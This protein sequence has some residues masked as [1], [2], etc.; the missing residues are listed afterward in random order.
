MLKYQR[1]FCLK[2]PALLVQ[3]LLVKH[4]HDVLANLS[5][6]SWV[7]PHMLGE[8]TLNLSPVLIQLQLNYTSLFPQVHVI[9]RNIPY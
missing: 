1:V 3:C 8:Y 6:S 5:I 7:N 4:A 9:Y 2:A